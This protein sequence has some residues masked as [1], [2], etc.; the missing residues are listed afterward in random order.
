MKENVQG[1]GHELREVTEAG[2]DKG[3]HELGVRDGVEG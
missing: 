3:M 1:V 2:R